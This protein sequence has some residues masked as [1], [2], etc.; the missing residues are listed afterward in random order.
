MVSAS[1]FGLQDPGF[2]SCWRQNSAQDCTALH[3][4]EPFI[5]TLALSQYDLNDV[6]RDVE[7]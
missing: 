7:H 2:E 3:C 4:T 6:E 1:K 5:I